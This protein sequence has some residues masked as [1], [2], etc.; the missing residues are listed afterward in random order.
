MGDYL[1]MKTK[2]IAIVILSNILL[3]N[4][5]ELSWVDEQIDAIKPPR[6]SP[7]IASVA[8]PFIFL[9]SNKSIKKDISPI[10]CASG[11]TTSKVKDEN[12]TVQEVY[13]LSTIINKKAM[14]NDTWYKKD[15]NI[16]KYKVLDITKTSVTLQD[17]K[18]KKKELILHTTTQNSIKFKNK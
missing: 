16:S 12:V 14:I 11:L 9:D 4:N 7:V 17:T 3:A 18:D 2:F 15:D 6:K 10:T 1:Q 8:D 13:N 5:S